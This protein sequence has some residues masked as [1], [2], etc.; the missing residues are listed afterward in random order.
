VAG[1]PA[2]D[3]TRSVVLMPED[4]NSPDP[5]EQ[6]PV[7]TT[8]DQVFLRPFSFGIFLP[9]EAEFTNVANPRDVD[10]DGDV[11]ASDVL[12][13]INNINAKGSRSLIG[14]MPAANAPMVD[15]NMDSQVTAIDVLTIINFIN[16]FSAAHTSG[17]TQG[18]TTAN[19]AAIDTSLTD[20][21]S[22]SGTQSSSLTTS[23]TP[24]L[25]TGGTPSTSDSSSSTTPTGTTSGS[26]TSSSSTSSTSGSVDAAAAD[27]IYANMITKQ[28]ILNLFGR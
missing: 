16:S 4:R 9:G 21:S 1:D 3:P 26:T 13:V 25:L 2:D 19:T 5:F 27:D 22:P 24:T 7:T 20:L 28:Q 8:D 17:G 15:V 18:S 23:S 10:L 6:L 12:T 11:S 14:E